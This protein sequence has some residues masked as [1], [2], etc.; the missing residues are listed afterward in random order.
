[1]TAK[2]IDGNAI[3]LKLRKKIAKEIKKLSLKP[4]LAII[5]VGKNPASLVYIKKKV[6]ACNE[7]GIKI[8]KFELSEN[9]SEKKLIQL[10][11]KL[12]ENRAVNGILVQL[13][14][15][16]QINVLNVMNAI[17]PLKDVDGFHPLNQGK[18][19]LGNEGLAACT[20]KGIIFLLKE[21]GVNLTGKKVV[22][23][24]TS[25]IVGKPLGL[26]LLNRN[27]TVIFC[28][29]FTKNLK[30]FC[31]QA[32]ILIVAVG[33]PGLITAEMVK[34]NA[35]VIDVGINRIN[36][37]IVGDVDFEKVKEK[38]LFITPVPGGVGP[39][40]VACLLENLLNALKLQK[41]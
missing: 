29:K 26:M 3:A 19:F 40:T 6:E 39:L 8:K 17:N 2:I 30:D 36:G 16:K 32:D 24:G 18:N 38:A 31:L 35:I 15:P 12:N 23:V 28:N 4:V 9:I 37:K 5:L 7:V 11:K 21:I 1:M 25:N 10:I 20:A 27:A 13:P 22:C 41:N 34:K 33:K 14:L